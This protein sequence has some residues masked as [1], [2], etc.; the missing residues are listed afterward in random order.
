[1]VAKLSNSLGHE[2][3]KQ[4]TIGFDCVFG[5]SMAGLTLVL[6]SR[7]HGTDPDWSL[8]KILCQRWLLSP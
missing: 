3:N 8:I 1:M 6:D 5:P 4:T 2:D 7:L